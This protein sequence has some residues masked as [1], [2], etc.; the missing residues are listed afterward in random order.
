MPESVEVEFYDYSWSQLI[1]GGFLTE[2]LGYGIT[3]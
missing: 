1:Q 2:L 3:G